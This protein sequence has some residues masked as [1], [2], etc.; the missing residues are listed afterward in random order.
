MRGLLIGD[1]TDLSPIVLEEMRRSG[2][3]H[4]V[5]VSGG[6][7]AVFV[8]AVWLLVGVLPLGPRARA[9]IGLAAVALFVLITRWEPSVVRAG[10]M[11]GLLLA[12][13]LAGV[14]VDGWTA[15]GG[16][17]T[18]ALLVAPQLVFELGFQL[19]VFATGGLL[20]G[21]A[22][23]SGRKP[24]VL[25]R[26]FGATVAAQLAV[27]PLLLARFGSVPAFSALAN[28]LAAPLVAMATALGW[29]R[30]V[31]PAPLLDEIA[32]TLAG[33][34]ISLASWSAA[35]PQVGWIGLA[36][37]ITAL[38]LIHR[39]PVTGVL[40]GFVLLALSLPTAPPTGP[41]V[42][43]LAIGQG[44]AVL[45]HTADGATVAVDTGPDPLQYA[46]A[47]RRNGVDHIELL[48][49]THSDGDHIGGLS[50]LSGRVQ[51]DEVWYP[52]FTAAGTWDHL[53]RNVAAE[54]EAV[55]RGD[56][57]ALGEYRLLVQSPARR[58]ASDNDG[59]VVLWIEGPG[60]PILLAGDI[61]SVGQGELPALRPNILLVPHHGSKTTDSSWLRST[62]GA[63]AV[64]SYGAN[65][66]G[67]PAPEIVAVLEQ[68]GTAL[69][70]TRHGD[71]A[72][73]L[74]GR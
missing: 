14:P 62:V 27:T 31:T 69:L 23:W 42:V 72:V 59:S 1:T 70:T 33:L 43:F 16:A 38:V 50:A 9:G 28:L 57:A 55:R 6:N 19:S 65:A 58:F 25:W 64:L 13:R 37:L 8:A 2:L 12:G 49:L 34:V 36:G 21:S 44:D 47:L 4:F 40:A 51:V 68:S 45:L 60:G 46:A 11:M 10:L 61:E 18:V 26:S 24:A 74:G 53:M 67:H 52:D 5:A 15:L 56:T 39:R 71:V 32:R 41:V 66:Y 54:W 48:V 22:A 73:P 30:V 35:L 63:T 3:L 20:L 29:A 7:V 17:A